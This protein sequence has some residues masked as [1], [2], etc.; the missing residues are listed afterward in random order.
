[1]LSWS[2]GRR[3]GRGASWK[4]SLQMLRGLCPSTP[5]SSKDAHWVSEDTTFGLGRGMA[6]TFL[7]SRPHRKLEEKPHQHQQSMTLTHP[8]EPYLLDM[9]CVKLWC[10]YQTSS[11]R[12]HTPVK[13][14][15]PMGDSR[16]GRLLQSSLYSLP[17]HVQ[18][19]QCR[20]TGDSR[21]F[22]YFMLQTHDCHGI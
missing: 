20:D 8:S 5:P 14:T 1:M 15:Y 3:L 13:Q 21:S 6:P 12:I 18:S 9:Y 16:W 7:N 11:R 4:S 17:S 19:S 22:L 2:L 10:L